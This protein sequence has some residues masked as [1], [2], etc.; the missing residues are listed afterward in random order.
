MGDVRDLDANF[1]SSRVADG[2][3]WWRSGYGIEGRGWSDAEPF[4]RLPDRAKDVVPEPVWWLSRNSAGISLEF[5]TDSPR[6]A[7]RWTVRGTTMAL[8][9]M[10]ASGVS[11]VDLYVHQRG[12]WR[13]SGIGRATTHPTNEAQLLRDLPREG[14]DHRLYLPLYNGVSEIEIGLDPE[15]AMVARAPRP[16]PVVVYGTSIV[17]GGCASRPGM[18]YPAIL[19]R[20]LDHPVTNL[21]FS[22]NARMELPLA[23]L[24]AEMEASV[25]VLDCL[26]NMSDVMV[27][28]RAEPFVRELRA[29]RSEPIVLIEN[30]V[31]QSGWIDGSGPAVSAKKNAAL[32]RAYESLV[33]SGVADL[34]C[35]PG[36]GLLGDDGEATVDGTHPT[37]LG[38][39]RMA[40]AIAPTLRAALR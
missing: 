28:E 7:V 14:R 26:P 38:F 34:H 15:A 30:I 17:N 13:W 19:G 9:H 37:D 6:L 24:L 3:R 2:L 18:A 36:D 23:R 8:D 29:R 35:V 31:Y 22:G 25:F 12:R 39:L 27:A 40:E 11:G 1:A 21:G 4:T 20:M 10:P 33:A 16:R 32:R 5:T